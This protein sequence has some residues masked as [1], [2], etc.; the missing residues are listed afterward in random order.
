MHQNIIYTLTAGL[1]I[2]LVLGFVTQKMKLSPII[3]YLIAGMIVGPFSPGFVADSSAANQ[4]AEIGIILLM[5]GI[6]LHFHIKD[7]L[8]VKHI[9]IPG[10]AA[11]IGATALFSMLLAHLFGWSWSA[12]LV[13]GISISV[14]ST[15]VL[16]RV[17]AENHTLHSPTGHLA[18]GWLIVEDL[19]TIFV[20]VLLPSFF[21]SHHSGI[22][23]IGWA[24]VLTII[25]LTALI[26]FALAFGR[27]LLP[28]I[29]S[30]VAKTGARD[31][32]TLVILVLALGMAVGAAEFF[33]AS[34]ALGAFL[35]GLVVGQSDFSARAA[36][37]ALPMRD[38]FAVLFF[39][40]VGMLFNPFSITSEW[41][42]VIAALFIVI[43]IKPLVAF[44]VVKL[45]G[46][47]STKALCVG[48]SLAQIGE[49]SFIL[50]GLGVS[51]GVLPENA[52][53]AIIVVAIISITLNPLLYRLIRPI[54]RFY[55]KR[56]F[57]DTENF[58]DEKVI[59]NTEHHRVIL[60]GYG[61]VGRVVSKILRFGQMDV[62]VIEMNI[63]TIKEIKKSSDDGL[64]AVYGD[65]SNKDVLQ[66][67]RIDD[68]EALIISP[69]NAPAQEIVEI[70]RS[71]NKDIKI[72]IHTNYLSEAAKLEK[73]G[74]QAVF[75]GEG[76]AAVDISKYLMCELS[77]MSEDF[78]AECRRI[79]AENEMP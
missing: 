59:A 43:V 37:E 67:A 22:N 76:A 58:D 14:A 47:S 10:A 56:G 55:K 38:A 52:A 49:F 69:S 57:K 8:A 19:F 16:T 32:F 4:F 74:V 68:A 63:D 20:L 48:V 53:S 27:K 21:T 41:Q 40:S 6:G 5:F 75:S 17:L 46:G 36:S 65:A 15:V 2:A 23:T 24:F 33:G 13:F 39:V 79:N 77:I 44:V 73:N 64:I 12:G 31:L 30:Y 18:I 25:K 1:S 78:E 71:L 3:G 60:V 34:M 7:L 35:A 54:M 62:V 11:Q 66:Y 42:L 61:P 29:L 45:L 51:L 50:A 72:I 28:L 9:A 70:A 26:A